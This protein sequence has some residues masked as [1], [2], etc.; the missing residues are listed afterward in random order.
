MYEMHNETLFAVCNETIDGT[1]GT[2]TSL[3]YPENYPNLAN[4]F[5][6][7][8]G[9]RGSY[10]EIQFTTMQFN[11]LQDCESDYVQINAGP[12]GKNSTWPTRP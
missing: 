9:P 4:C 7:I 10:I 3:N 6:E 1:S 12:P 5:T 8:R 11:N 2:I